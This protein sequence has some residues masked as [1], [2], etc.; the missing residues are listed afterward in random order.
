MRSTASCGIRMRSS[1]SAAVDGDFNW[2][3]GRAGSRGF[4]FLPSHCSA[5]ADGSV[6][7][8]MRFHRIPLSVTSRAVRTWVPS[9]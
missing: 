7:M 4:L 8:V 5:G 9:G 3:A 6:G 2:T 1:A